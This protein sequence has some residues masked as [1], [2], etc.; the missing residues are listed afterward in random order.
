MRVIALHL[1]PAR[2]ISE[3]IAAQ[4]DELLQML[5]VYIWRMGIASSTGDVDGLASELLNDVV[6][7]ALDHASRFDP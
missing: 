7:E 3:Y 1:D 2:H 5:R 4:S 6:V